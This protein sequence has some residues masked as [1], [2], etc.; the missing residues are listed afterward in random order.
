M[1]MQFNDAARLSMRLAELEAQR[2]RRG[3]IDTEHLLLALLEM[4]GCVASR[5][6]KEGQIDAIRVAQEAA[7]LAPPGD[8]D[9]LDER[10]PLTSGCQKAIDF[11]TAAAERF[12]HA[13]VGTG[14]L[15]LGLLEEAEGVAYRVLCTL[16]IVRVGWNLSRVA[17][18]VIVAMEDRH[19]SPPSGPFGG[20]TDPE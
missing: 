14:H 7:K 20:A 11:A 5:V 8:A 6:L 13:R 15:L 4:R 3:C 17:E 10:P 12:G 2:S 9:D 1:F 19:S 18:R 16:N